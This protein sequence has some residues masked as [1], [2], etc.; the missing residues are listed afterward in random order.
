MAS[1][2]PFPRIPHIA[3]TDVELG[4]RLGSGAN[5]AVYD[6]FVIST[7]FDQVRPSSSLRT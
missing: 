5:C 4:T 1:S 3:A 2:Q 7:G 6:A